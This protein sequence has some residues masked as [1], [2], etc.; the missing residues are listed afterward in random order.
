MFLRQT[1]T[2]SLASLTVDAGNFSPQGKSLADS[3]KARAITGFFQRM[4]YDAVTLS[5]RETSFGIGLW[6]DAAKNGFPAV[7]ANVYS[8]RKAKKPAFGKDRQF[9]IV[10]R[11]NRKLGVIGFVSE[12]A[13]KAT[14]RDSTF[15]M[16]YK[17]PFAMGKL[18]KKVAKKCDYLTVIGEFSEVEADSLAKTFPQIDMIASSGIRTDSPRHKGNTVIMGA[19]GQGVD[20]TYADWNPAAADSSTRFV[21]KIISLDT[22][23]P[24]DSVG[25][26]IVEE[27]NTQIRDAQQAIK[28]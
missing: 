16:S 10:E 21:S 11:H 13:W 22:S 5:A 12:S 23:M 4:K 1:R 27:I 20:G 19:V 17:S 9:V 18:I 8:D 28:K 6:Q 25:N 14:R 15:Q 2:D 26:K 7:V 3:V 24:K